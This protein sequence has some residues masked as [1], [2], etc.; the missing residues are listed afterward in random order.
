MQPALATPGTA[1][2][3]AG[4][5]YLAI[6]FGG[7][8]AEAFVRQRMLVPGA[9]AATARNILAGDSLYRLG[10]G[11]HLFHLACAV[12]VAVILYRLLRTVHRGIAQLGLAFD[13]TSIAI[14]GA[15]L[16][17][18]YAPLRLLD[19]AAAFS[20]GSA[21]AMAY[22]SL[23]LFSSGFGIALVFFAGFCAATGYLIWR[24]GF[25]P[26]TLGVLMMV[27]GACYFA[28]SFL[29]FLLPHLADALFPY[30]L[31]PC[32]VAELSLALWL[33]VVGVRA[34][35]WQELGPLPA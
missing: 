7:V 16:L 20:A 9:P 35:T 33:A 13:L 12:P 24:S 25:L 19:D 32:L 27:A 31:L 1:A 30:I 29:V 26:R 11:V 28:N 15:N 17:N 6:V 23:R 34:R 14:E 22:A 10:F 8:F 18:L 5:L 2:R 4:F 3:I 21:Q